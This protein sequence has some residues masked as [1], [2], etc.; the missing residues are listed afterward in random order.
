MHKLEE[1]L[2][3]HFIEFI[4]VM[5]LACIGLVAYGLLMS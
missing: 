2:M 5:S 1:W 4:I 3:E